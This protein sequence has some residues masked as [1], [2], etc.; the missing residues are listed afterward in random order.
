MSEVQ[1]KVNCDTDSSQ[2]FR[3]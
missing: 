2:T 1:G 3:Y